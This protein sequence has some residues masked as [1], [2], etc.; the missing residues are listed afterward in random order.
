MK[1]LLLAFIGLFFSCSLTA[2]YYNKNDRFI[3]GLNGGVVK[4]L[5]NFADESSLG[6]DLCLNAKMLLN[7]KLAVGFSLG[8]MNFGQD[9]AYWNGDVRRKN[10][11]N[12]QIIPI[13]FTGTYFI[14][15]YDLDFRPYVSLGFGYFLYRNHVESIP[16]NTYSPEK[17]EHTVSTNKIG[18][19][20][21]VGFMYNVSKKL[22]VDVNLKLTYIPN[23]E[24]KLEKKKVKPSV[25][26]NIELTDLQKYRYLGFDKI[27]SASL[28][29][30]LY[31]RF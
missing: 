25:D 22:A 5:S 23:F 11:V 15:A 12:Y 10:D 16:T 19:M 30:G 27:T 31:Y 18:L 17:E 13:T 3:V 9:D 20:P 1:T 8:Y 28:T 14:Q 2:Q 4:P 24:E 7:Q 26:E 21:N 29:V 6:T